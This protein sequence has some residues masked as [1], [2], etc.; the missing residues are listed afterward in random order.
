MQKAMQRA[1]GRCTYHNKK[2]KLDEMSE[3]VVP[4]STTE[5]WLYG[6]LRR[7]NT[8]HPSPL[9]VHLHFSILSAGQSIRGSREEQRKI[10]SAKF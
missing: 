5:K 9:E 10:R 6:H 2:H 3:K 1:L 8:V 7:D 4:P